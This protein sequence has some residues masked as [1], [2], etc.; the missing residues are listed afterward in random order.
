MEEGG[1]HVFRHP[2]SLCLLVLLLDRTTTR[3]HAIRVRFRVAFLAQVGLARQLNSKERKGN[4]LTPSPDLPGAIKIFRIGSLCSCCSFPYGSQYYPLSSVFCCEELSA[5]IP[6]P[7]SKF[8]GLV[9]QE[10]PGL[11]LQL[12]IIH[13]RSPSPCFQF[14]N[15][16]H[17]MP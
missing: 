2:L 14:G 13:S 10:Q 3:R 9:G 12:L 1:G 7:L 11:A 17:P 6:L 4:I 8:K 5:R 16:V 15:C